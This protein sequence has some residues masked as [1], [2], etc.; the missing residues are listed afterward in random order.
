MKECQLF[1][2][3][4]TFLEQAG[5]TVYSEVCPFGG[6]WRADVVGISGKI[7]TVVEMKKSLN[8]EVIHQALQWKPY[9]HH[10]YI[11]IPRGR[12]WIHP[13]V[14]KLLLQEGIGLIEVHPPNHLTSEPFAAGYLTPKLTRSI[15]SDLRDFIGHDVLANPVGGTNEGGYVTPYKR[16]MEQV[17]TLLRRKPRKW[18]SL[19]EIIEEVHTHYHSPKSSLAQAL[20]SLEKD[21]CETKLENRRRY[22]R[23]KEGS[24]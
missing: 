15:Q 4:K 8:F 17:K 10:V 9:A 18:F 22:Y 12:K 21:W 3:V 14:K 6:G 16:T 11:A 23:Y 7:V 5:Y 24:Q 1:V 2:P 20:L 13:Y 19:N